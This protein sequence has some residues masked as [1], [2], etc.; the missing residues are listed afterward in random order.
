MDMTLATVNESV[1]AIAAERCREKGIVI[2]TL[3]QMKDPSLIPAATREKLKSVGLWD[4]DPLNLFRITWKNDAGTGL[5]NDGNFVE[6][7]S[8]LTGVDARIIGLVGHWLP[9]GAHNVGAA[10]G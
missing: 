8:S 9:T 7:P 6:F 3:A 2:P 5:F 10:F 4:I 1:V